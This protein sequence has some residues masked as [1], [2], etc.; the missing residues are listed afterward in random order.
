MLLTL[1]FRLTADEFLEGQR[2]FNRLLAPTFARFNYRYGIAVG[3][4]LL[5][6]GVVAFALRWNIGLSVLL[7][8]FGAYLI[9]CRVVLGPRR[10]KREF[11]QYRDFARD[12]IW[13]F[14]EEK[15]LV[16][17]SHT[18]SEVDW[19]RFTRFVETDKIFLLCVPPRFLHIIPKRV[20]S[21]SE[22]DQFRKLLRRKLPGK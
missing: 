14:G 20:F 8:V 6:E 2:V 13:E 7:V 17:T 22:S 19:A 18:K 10:L 9:L 21:P 11:A 3:V 15:I 5:A 12:Q 4:L 16:Q 1:K